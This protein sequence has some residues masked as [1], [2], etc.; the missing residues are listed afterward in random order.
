MKHLRPAILGF[1]LVVLSNGGALAA[2][3]AGVIKEPVAPVLTP[4]G[5]R[6]GLIP[7]AG[8]V[9]TGIT[10]AGTPLVAYLSWNA[11]PD[12]QRYAV[13]RLDGMNPSLEVTP[14]GFTGTQFQNVVPDPRVTYGYVIVAYYANGTSAEAP[15]VQ[16]ISPPMINPPGFSARDLGQGQVYFQWQPVPGA[17]LYRLDGPGLPNTGYF[18]R[19]TNTSAAYPHTPAG[20]DSWRLVALYPGNYG[21]YPGASIASTVIRVLPPHSQ[22]WL[23]KSNGAGALAQVQTPDQSSDYDC[24]GPSGQLSLAYTPAA[25]VWLGNFQDACNIAYGPGRFGLNFWLDINSLLWDDPGQAANEAVYGNP[26]DLG[27]GRRTFCEQKLRGP[28]VTG[29]YTVCYATAH[30]IPPGQAG[31]N[32]PQVITHPH[33]GGG[34]DFLLS[35]VIT[36]DASGSAFLVFSNAGQYSMSPTV[37]LDTEGAKLVPFA[38]L[39]CH[40]GKYNATTRKVDGAS[41]LPLDPGLLAF[42]S[43]ADQAA[44][45]EKIRSINLMIYNSDPRSPIGA[46]IRGLYRGAPG[47]PGARATSDYVPA[48]WAAQAGFYRQ[49]VRPYCTMCHLAQANSSYNFASW[50][51]FQAYGAL[52]Q[53]SVCG[54]HTMPHSEPQYKAFWLKDTG[55]LYLPGLL[56]ATLGFQSCP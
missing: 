18:V 32:D 44:Q 39:S 26:G 46:Y 50:G 22:Q 16:F 51:N 27:V 1:C 31:F 29:M 34:D 35:M 36:K 23:T 47:Q 6:P 3:L 52:I 20:P 12:A 17:V 41:L 56:S 4:I 37:R 7:V 49:V 48:G 5:P 14:T 9:P 10:V 15:A 21:D 11:M 40:G 13:F 55:P 53:A 8:P 43:P 42:A 33:E 54:A 45:E 30:G 2:P 28:P 25:V 24:R 19:G 38:C